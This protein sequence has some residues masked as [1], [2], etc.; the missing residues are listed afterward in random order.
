MGLIDIIKPMST[1]LSS[2]VNKSPQDQEKNSNEHQESNP[3]QPG[4]K[5]VCCLCAMQSL[6]GQ[7]CLHPIN[8]CFLK[9]KNPPT[10]LHHLKSRINFRLKIIPTFKKCN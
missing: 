3:G 9:A 6:N 10:S 1:V 4:E 2:V 7:L 5:Q 8:A